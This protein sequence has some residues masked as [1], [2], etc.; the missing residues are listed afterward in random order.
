MFFCNYDSNSLCCHNNT[1]SVRHDGWPKPKFWSNCIFTIRWSKKSSRSWVSSFLMRNR[2]QFFCNWQQF[3][4]T[5]NNEL[6]EDWKY[7]S[8]SASKL[9][10]WG[11]IEYL[12]K[13]S[14]K[15][16]IRAI[17]RLDPVSSN[18]SYEG[19][20][21]YLLNWFKRQITCNQKYIWQCIRW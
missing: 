15:R 5:V 14:K 19:G 2:P 10:P 20:C 16:K 8:L 11:V 13:Q 1:Q 4:K 21:T 12:S 9:F 17:T 7:A 18:K 6:E 3:L